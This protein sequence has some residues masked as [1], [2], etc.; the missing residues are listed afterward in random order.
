VQIVAPNLRGALITDDLL[1]LSRRSREAAADKIIQHELLQSFD[2]AH[3]PLF[4]TRLLRLAQQEHLLLIA[5]H[6]IIVD[7]WS[8]GV[9]TNELAA[10]YESF[11]AGHKSPLSP[12]ALQF[13]D[14]ASWQR[15]WRSQPDVRAQLAYWQ[16]QLSAP[17]AILDFGGGR[18][19]P[20]TAVPQTAQREVVLPPR[21]VRALTEFSHR[22]SGTLFMALVTGLKILLNRYTGEIDLRVA[23]NV[24]NRNRPAT[25]KLIGPLVN[26]VV[27]RTGLGD[28]PTVREVLRRVRVTTL[29]A[30][31]NQDIP[32]EEVAAALAQNADRPT[33]V[34]QV[35]IL[36]HNATLRPIISSGK[37][38]A[39]EEA[40]P[41]MLMPLVTATSY[42]VILVLREGANGLVGWC[43]YKPDLI[44]AKSIDRLMRGFRIILNA[45][46]EDPECRLSE[47]P[48][49]LKR[50]R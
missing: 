13:G 44:G 36:L 9:L 6:Q 11:I 1:H 49:S 4:R 33:N 21:L 38:L 2:L 17:L 16:K 27:L 12:L 18:R 37:T 31:A 19:V 50:K 30:Y 48:V 40:D 20:K 34:A 24:A 22:E 14:F 26:T 25:E 41:N 35:M 10:L 29:A 45:M 42:D 23:T 7:G 43:I 39:F 5:M 47:I 3:G 32:F 28:D 46:V 15:R 8:L